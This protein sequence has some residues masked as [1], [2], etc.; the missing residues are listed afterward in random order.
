MSFLATTMLFSV[1]L[2]LVSAGHS[3]KASSNCG[4]L[5]TAGLA[6]RLL[7]PGTE[8]YDAREATYWDTGAQLGPWCILQ[9]QRTTE[10][11]SAVKALANTAD[12]QFAIRSGGKNMIPGAANIMDGVTID[13]VNMNDTTYH[14]DT[15]LVSVRP[16]SLWGKVYETLDKLNMTVT[17]GRASMVGVGGFM[18]GGGNSYFTARNGLACDTVQAFE[19]VLGNGDIVVADK[20]HNPDLFVALKGGGNNLGIVTRFDMTPTKLAENGVWGG[21]V[22]YP[23]A[24]GDKLIEAFVRFADLVPEN[25]GASTAIFWSYNPLIKGSV[26]VASY[27]NLDGIGDGLAHQELLEI[28]PTIQR[29][30]RFA[31]VTDIADEIVMP[32]GYENIWYTLNYKNDARIIKKAVELHDALVE[33][34]QK[35]SATGD[36]TTLNIFQPFPASFGQKGAKSKTGTG[37]IMGIDRM[38]ETEVLWLGALSVRSKENRQV[39]D[40][41]VAAWTKG[42]QDY[43][44]SLGK[45][46]EFLYM[47]Y[48]SPF[49]SNVLASYGAENLKRLAAASKKYDPLGIFQTRVPG[50]FKVSTAMAELDGEDHQKGPTIFGKDEL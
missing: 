49:Q 15:G 33:E 14:P 41:K 29:M 8:E 32:Y 36:F 1:L 30:T 37:N 25:E 23:P 22:L 46:A 3:T 28:E 21:T 26:I 12:C 48:A 2:S 20:D 17:G 44:R 27:L 10:V 40:Q 6:E 7:F 50:G 47:N 18:M 5:S 9:P 42:V 24:A 38:Q 34:M 4:A 35:E 45:E 11:S 13:L 39:A 19:V 31:N 43:A 16:G